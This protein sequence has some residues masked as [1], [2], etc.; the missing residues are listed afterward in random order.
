M[1]HAVCLTVCAALITRC[2][3]RP[4]ARRSNF[5]PG[6]PM[7]WQPR[8]GQTPA[9]GGS[10]RQRSHVGQ[11]GMA[12]L[13]LQ[14]AIGQKI[15]QQRGRL[16][17]PA[18]IAPAHQRHLQAAQATARAVVLGARRHGYAVIAAVEQHGRL[19]RARAAR[20]AL[21]PVGQQAAG[22]MQGVVVG[23]LEWR[24]AFRIT[25]SQACSPL[26]KRIK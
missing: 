3:H 17:L 23:I 1:L 25:L 10:R 26:K 14:A 16:R 8:M 21:H 4:F 13:H 19:R 20:Q 22:V 9:P 18:R 2:R 6:R 7:Y 5:A 15:R 24:T 11:G 12:T